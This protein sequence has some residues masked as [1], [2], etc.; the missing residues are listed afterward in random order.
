MFWKRV[1]G[2]DRLKVIFVALAT[3]SCFNALPA[4]A[5]TLNVPSTQ[6]P[7]IQSAIDAARL[8]DTI[9]VE[10]GRTYTENLVL[11]YKSSGSGWI[12]IQSSKLNLL[13]AEG[14]RV[15]PSDAA[16]MPTLRSG[17]I[18]QPVIKTVSGSTPSHHYK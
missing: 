11:K 15:S 17:N 18:E 13:P 6:Y 7:T 4:E 10:A 16:N 9:V 14:N 3:V 2:I 5:A 8:G 12:T 1:F